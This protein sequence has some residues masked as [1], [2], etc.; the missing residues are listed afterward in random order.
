MAKTT[1]ANLKIEVGRYFE[2]GTPSTTT[3][4]T[5]LDITQW[6][7]DAQWDI[8]LKVPAY[9]LREML[10][11]ENPSLAA[12]SEHPLASFATYTFLRFVS[13]TLNTSGILTDIPMRLVNPDIAPAIVTNELLGTAVSPICWIE[14]SK[15]KWSPATT[16]GAATGKLKVKYIKAPTDLSGDS[17]TITLPQEYEQAC[18][19]Y[20]VAQGFFQDEEFDKGQ[21]FLGAY[22]DSL[23][24]IIKN[25][26]P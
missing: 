13:A 11:I 4:P 12:V 6:I 3:D 23:S 18:I 7:N 2:I 26:R 17:D 21:F 19:F 10:V 14:E 16:G 15:L 5:A 9:C 25:W 20:A 1:H 22:A 24:T 8:A